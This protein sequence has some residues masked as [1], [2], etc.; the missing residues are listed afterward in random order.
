MKAYLDIETSFEGPITII[1]VYAEERG[2][3]Q[4]V[5][6]DVTDVGLMR[7][8]RG[9]GTICTYN[10]SRFD[11]PVIQRR[12]GVDLGRAFGSEDLMHRCWRVGLKGGLKR[13]EEQLGIPR[14][15]KGIDGAM[16]MRLWRAYDTLGDREALAALL[17]YNREDVMNL[18]LLDEYVTRREAIESVGGEVQAARHARPRPKAEARPSRRYEPET[19]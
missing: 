16:A 1:G 9:V 17:E 7:A 4:L 13:I 6:G 12:L 18:V 19:A 3:V 2:L 15:S 11:L 5:G 14:R 10:G 8:L